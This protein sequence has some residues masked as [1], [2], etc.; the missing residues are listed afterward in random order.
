[1]WVLLL[2]SGACSDS[3]ND[4]P[5][6]T[7]P[8]IFMNLKKCPVAGAYKG[9]ILD[10]SYPDNNGY[11]GI[12]CYVT[13]A[14]QDAASKKAPCLGSYIFFE[15]SDFE[16][17]VLPVGKTISFR[18]LRYEIDNYHY[19]NWLLFKYYYYYNCKVKPL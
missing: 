16:G 10:L 11:D 13:D 17:I 3:E 4:E 8:G 1:M 15:K 14:P 7:E 5:Q 18:I 9:E 2:V 19:H 6:P 12:W